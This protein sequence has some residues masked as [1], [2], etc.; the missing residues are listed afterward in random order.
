MDY[1]EEGRNAE[2]FENFR[3]WPNVRP[4][5]LLD[6]LVSSRSYHLE[7]IEERSPR[8]SIL[9]GRGIHPPDV[10]KLIAGLISSSFWKAD[11]SPIRTLE[12]YASSR[13]AAGFLRFRMVGRISPAS[14][15]DD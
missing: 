9:S 11:F 15:H 4:E 13:R 6:S 8:F 14:D 1:V 12:I 10:V 7:F 3:K 5:D 2:V